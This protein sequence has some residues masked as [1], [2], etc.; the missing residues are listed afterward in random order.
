MANPFIWILEKILG[1]RMT[2]AERIA[3]NKKQAGLDSGAGPPVTQDELDQFKARILAMEAPVMACHPQ[4]GQTSSRPDESRLGG[5]PGWPEDEDLPIGSNG[6]PMLFLAQINFAEM[7]PFDPFPPAG[8]MQIFVTSDDLY[9]CNFPSRNREGFI[10]IYRA[11]T[12]KLQTINPYPNDMDKDYSVFSGDLHEVGRPIVFETATMVPPVEHYLIAAQG[13]AMW[14]RD[15]STDF[16]QI[17]TFFEGRHGP[18]MYLGGYPRFTQDDIRSPDQL[19]DYDQVIMQFGAPPDMMWGD[20]GEACFLMRLD[21]LQ[22]R[23]FE[24]AIYNWDC[25]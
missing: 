11:E 1:P 18:A 14:Q 3:H 10:V 8:L 22:D 17:D 9:G 6:K 12:G 25:S 21:D 19:A 16:D 7:P 15:R 2:T 20:V 13:Q 24:K 5:W 4:T 23:A